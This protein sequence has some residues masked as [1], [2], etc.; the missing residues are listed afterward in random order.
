MEWKDVLERFLPKIIVDWFDITCIEDDELAKRM[1]LYLDEKKL[2]PDEIKHKQVVSD[3]FTQECVVQDFPIRGRGVYLHVR[4]RKWK[5]KDTGHIYSRRFDIQH[6][7]TELTQEFVAF[8]K[9]EN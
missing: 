5:D 3:G 1:D 4:R 2:I 6:K 7:G 8:L 9:G